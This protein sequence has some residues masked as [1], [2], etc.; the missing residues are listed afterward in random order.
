MDTQAIIAALDQEIARLHEVR[1]LLGSAAK[2]KGAAS[3]KKGPG[4]PEKLAA[5]KSSG[6][7]AESLKRGGRSRG[8]DGA[9]GKARKA[10]KKAAKA[11]K[12]LLGALNPGIMPGFSFSLSNLV[13][14]ELSRERISLLR[15]NSTRGAEP[16]AS[17]RCSAN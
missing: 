16:C 3:I 12:R 6:L 15:M 11:E 17:S 4:R 8:T 9:V 5:V 10:A 7:D 14:Y 2:V 1:A 13:A